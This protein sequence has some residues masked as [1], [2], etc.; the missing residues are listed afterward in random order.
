MYFN[1]F[2]GVWDKV[3]T[4]FE[5]EMTDF[6]QVLGERSCMPCHPD[7]KLDSLMLSFARCPEGQPRLKESAVGA[8]A[9]AMDVDDGWTLE[10]AEGALRSLGAPYVLHTT[11][12]SMPDAHRFRIL[13]F[14]SR[15]VDAV[16]YEHLWLGLA[17][18]WGVKMDERTRDI[19]RLS[20]LPAKWDGA[21]NDFRWCLDGT[22]LDVDAML[23]ALPSFE[24]LD[25]TSSN[26]RTC[27]APPT[28]ARQV[29]PNQRFDRGREQR[30]VFAQHRSDMLRLKLEAMS[31]AE[32]TDLDTS[33]LVPDKALSE[34]MSSRP[35]GRTYKLLLSV[36][37]KARW[38]GYDLDQFDLEEIGRQFSNRVGRQTTAFELR[39]DASRALGK[40]RGL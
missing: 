30:D 9:L 38:C 22:L 34:A 4:S 20:A 26:T 17:G 37:A 16:E 7:D 28:N 35:G 32:R 3:G 33:P 11:T 15:E 27:S 24:S 29:I 36:A 2:S 14:L 10:K 39:R 31:P 40:A 8:A 18:R 25:P 19:S 5:C 21:F 13:L 6:F 12:N 23:A 1:L